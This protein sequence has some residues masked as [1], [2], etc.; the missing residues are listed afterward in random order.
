MR[1]TELIGALGAALAIGCSQ[2]HPIVICHNANCGEPTDP[3]RD[4]T[5]QAFRE[6]L[7]LEDYGRPVIDGIELDS[8]WRGSDDVCLY[9]R[10]VSDFAENTP[11]IAPPPRDL[12]P[13]ALA[14]PRLHPGEAVTT[15]PGQVRRC[16]KC[17]GR[18]RR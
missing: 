9:A 5:L 10:D 1:V 17:G 18:E 6:S 15:T 16:R 3:A 11:A 13:P 4:D 14:C 2:P 12:W 8:F 7:A